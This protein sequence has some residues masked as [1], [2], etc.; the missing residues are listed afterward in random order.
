M[1]KSG[2]ASRSKY[3]YIGNTEHRGTCFY[4]TTGDM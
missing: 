1:P 3:Q 2:Q 4:K